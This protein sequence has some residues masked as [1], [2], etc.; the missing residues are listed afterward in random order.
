MGKNGKTQND[1][2]LECKEKCVCKSMNHRHQDA[3][4]RQRADW[5]IG[6]LLLYFL[7]ENE[8]KT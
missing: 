7:E 3:A 1:Y 6:F 2:C 8:K 5:K 4:A